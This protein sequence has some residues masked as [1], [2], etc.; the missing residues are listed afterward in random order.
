MHSQNLMQPEYY[1]TDTK[2]FYSLLQMTC[3]LKIAKSSISPLLKKHLHYTTPILAIKFNQIMSSNHQKSHHSGKKNTHLPLPHHTAPLRS[4]NSDPPTISPSPPI[5][6]STAEELR[7]TSRPE[8]A[9]GLQSLL[10]AVRIVQR[11]SIGSE[12]AVFFNYKI[13]GEDDDAGD[14]WERSFGLISER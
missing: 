12:T 7:R 13:A 9:A 4:S 3:R 14:G 5:S 8:A 11:F 2:T 10:L 6:I 1:S